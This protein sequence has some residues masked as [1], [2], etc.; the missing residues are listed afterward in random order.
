[1]RFAILLLTPGLLMAAGLAPADLLR[2]Q[3]VDGVALSPDGL[4]VA[5]TVSK[6]D[7]PLRPYSQ[8][9]IRTLAS[10]TTVALSS[11]MDKSANPVWSPDSTRI[12]YSGK[13]GEKSGLIVAN[14]DGSSKRFLTKL[15]GTNAP[16]PSTGETFDWSP[17]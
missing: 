9:L 6:Q 11:G 14:A 1:M 8:L 15:D 3:S 10:G 2:L 17:D 5:Y 4:R 12:A 16:L 13:L 7:G